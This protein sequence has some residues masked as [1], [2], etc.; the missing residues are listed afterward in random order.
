M[1]HLSSLCSRK[2]LNLDIGNTKLVNLFK[3]YISFR[4]KCINS[5]IFSD[6]N[7]YGFYISYKDILL[8]D[9]D[10]LTISRKDGSSLSLDPSILLE[11]FTQL[12]KSKG[13]FVQNSDLLIDE[14]SFYL[15]DNS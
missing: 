3:T 12:A 13:F 10:K 11:K 9:V 5:E 7:L 1:T 4:T 8:S 15:V 14:F 2:S 6:R